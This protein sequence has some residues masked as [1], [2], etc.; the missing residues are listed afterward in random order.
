MHFQ[1]VASTTAP[2]SETR[3]E[4]VTPKLRL[5]TPILDTFFGSSINCQDFL[6]VSQRKLWHFH[7]Y[8]RIDT[9]LWS[10]YEEDGCAD[11]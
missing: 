10:P 8:Y 7:K 2:C 4:W 6:L 3:M 11:R 5:V 1:S 9:I